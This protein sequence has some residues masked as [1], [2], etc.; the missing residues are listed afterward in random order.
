MDRFQNEDKYKMT[1]NVM[2][3]TSVGELGRESN[4]LAF[5]SALATYLQYKL[6]WKMFTVTAGLRNENIFLQEKIMVKMTPKGTV[7]H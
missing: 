1:N 6:N 3:Q 2:L 5:A 4:K 7:Q